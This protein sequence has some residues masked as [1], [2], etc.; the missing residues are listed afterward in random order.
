MSVLIDLF[1]IWLVRLKK[2]NN[3]AGLYVEQRNYFPHLQNS[4][5]GKRVLDSVLDSQVSFRCILFF[6]NISHCT[7]PFCTTPS[8][9][10]SYS[11]AVRLFPCLFNSL[12]AFFD[13]VFFLPLLLKSRDTHSLTVGSGLMSLCWDNVKAFVCGLLPA[14]WSGVLYCRT[15]VFCCVIMQ[16]SPI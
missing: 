10:I 6:L 8:S 16:L 1:L 11:V 5:K 7:D 3:I 9:C 2:N 4:Q 15:M 13:Y 14:P 12:T